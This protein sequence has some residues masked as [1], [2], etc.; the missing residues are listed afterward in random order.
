MDWVIDLYNKLIE[1]LYRLI[2]SLVDMLKDMF[3]WCIEVLF[4]AMTFVIT[5]VMSLFGVIDMSQFVGSIP[6]EMAWMFSAIGI[7]QCL[8]MITTALGIR[9]LMQLIPFTRLG[10]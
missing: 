10:S 5:K 3:F 9:L 2:L 1:F 4:E 8:A 7:P 6:P